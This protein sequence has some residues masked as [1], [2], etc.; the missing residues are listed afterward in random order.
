MFAVGYARYSTDKQTENSIIYQTDAI[1]KYC[2]KNRLSLITI[3]SDQAETG[4]NINRP[5][6]QALISAAKRKEFDVVVIY[7]IS[8][9]SRDVADWF[10]FRKE[11]T[12]LG[13]KVESATQQLGDFT[14]PNAFLTELLTAG[15]GQHS[16][17][18]TRQKS[19]AGVAER[20]KEGMF[21]GGIPPLGYD[22]KDGFYVI[23]SGEAQIVRKIFKMYSEGF[24]Y[25]EII[26]SLNNATGKKG[27]PF[28]KNSMNSILRNERYIGVYSWNKRRMKLFRQWAGGELNPDVIRIEDVIPPIIDKDI[29][30]RVQIR[31]NNNK[32][33]ASNKAK[34]EYLLSGKIECGSCGAAYIGHTS[35]NQKGIE[36][37]RY[38]CGN[39]YRTHSCDSHNINADEIETF[40]IQHIRKYIKEI[41]FDEAVKGIS[42]Q[43]N[44]SGKKDFS[45]EKE[46]ILE[47]DRKIKNGINAVMSGMDIPEIKEEIERL[48]ERKLELENIMSYS[49]IEDKAISEAEIQQCLKEI[50]EEAN[51][52]DAR[53]LVNTF[54]QKIYANPDGTIAI[55][56]SV[57]INGCGR[58]I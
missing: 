58:R 10:S 37:R 14:D 54:L 25:N 23:N 32:R 49:A 2:E 26:K 41:N 42:E 31:M 9:A 47:I 18:Q 16:V 7:D 15:L 55:H 34:R 3:F 8:R 43:I 44:K 51:A 17:L 4:T 19:I 56:L 29:W 38:C 35:T 48:R 40:V 24:S 50:V 53:T 46:E 57:H 12:R 52:K 39:K 33:N 36:S 11:M 28:G 30:E 1:T 27:R 20:A 13:I 5:G 22:I 45:A 21:L 6:F